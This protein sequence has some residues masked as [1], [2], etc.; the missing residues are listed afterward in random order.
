MAKL[1]EEVIWRQP[2]KH[3][4]VLKR[5]N[6]VIK[7]I[8]DGG[9]KAAYYR[10]K[11]ANALHPAS[12]LNIHVG[13]DREFSGEQWSRWQ[14]DPRNLHFIRQAWNL[15]H[16]RE[17]CAECRTH[18]KFASGAKVRQ[19]YLDLQQSGIGVDLVETNIAEINGKPIF[20]EVDQVIPEMVLKAAAKRD[21][22]T[23]ASVKS[24]LEKLE[25]HTSH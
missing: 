7:R 9:G 18:R 6:W 12:V 4:V 5:G 8:H 21:I 16:D 2:T 19:A 11:I 20:F 15:R 25:K 24:W 14:D 13:V 17:K 23:Q 22:K 10:H 3:N 1:P